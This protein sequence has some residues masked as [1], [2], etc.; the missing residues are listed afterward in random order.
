MAQ[1]KRED[2]VVATMIR[3]S[4]T[5]TRDWSP[6]VRLGCLGQAMTMYDQR[7]KREFIDMA[8]TTEA[9][10]KEVV[11]LRKR[12]VDL[13]H[14]LAIIEEQERQHYREMDAWCDEQEMAEFAEAAR[15][16]GL[17]L[18]YAAAK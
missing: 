5:Q 1:D 17:E 11:G 7:L 8:D 18:L 15:N 16:E 9:L 13:S 14:E 2:A 12:E 6:G 4:I 3:A 10:E